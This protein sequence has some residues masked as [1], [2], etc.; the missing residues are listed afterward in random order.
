[1]EEGVGTSYNGQALKHEWGRWEETATNEDGGGGK[2]EIESGWM[3]TWVRQKLGES[4]LVGV[5][6]VNLGDG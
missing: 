4:D 5:T 3:L 6:E 1:M 2:M